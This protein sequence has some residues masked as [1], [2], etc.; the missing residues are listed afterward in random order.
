MDVG[1]LMTCR[2]HHHRPHGELMAIGDRSGE[3][4]AGVDGQRREDGED[5]LLERL[6]QE[7]LVVL[8][9]VGPRREP[10][11]GRGQGGRHQVEEGG[12]HAREQDVEP[13][14]AWFNR[15]TREQFMGEPVKR[16]P[17][18]EV[19]IMV[20]EGSRDDPESMLYAFKLHRG[21]LPVLEE[22]NW[23]IPIVVEEF[24]ADGDIDKAVKHAAEKTYGVKDARYTWTDTVRY[25]GIYHAIPPSSEAL[26][27]LDCHS[28]GGRLDWKGLGY[29]EDP[30]EVLFEKPGVR[31]RV[32]GRTDSTGPA[33]YN[34][35][36]SRRRALSVRNH[37]VEAGLEIALPLFDRN[38]GH[39][40]ETLA[41]IKRAEHNTRKVESELSAQLG[42]AK[43]R[44][45]LAGRQLATHEEK[46]APAASRGLEQA[47]A[48]YRA[49]RL[50]FLE[51]LE[52]QKT[53]ARVRTR[54]LELQRD[55][56][57]AP[58]GEGGGQVHRG[59]RVIDD[60]VDRRAVDCYAGYVEVSPVFP[61]QIDERIIE[62]SSHISHQRRI[63]R[64]IRVGIEMQVK[65][66]ERVRRVVRVFDLLRA[67]EH[68]IFGV[69]ADPDRVIHRLLEV[70]G[71]DA[72]GRYE[73]RCN[74]ECH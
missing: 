21:K 73:Q 6:H 5:A 25:M 69:E 74:S 38:Q 45:S 23:L 72:R 16:V 15:K 2:V 7:L 36:L 56:H 31:V 33:V 70:L 18:G 55:L 14:Y 24:F 59:D 20:P 40:D 3:R 54:T 13:V 46:I 65:L 44:R 17:T 11:A 64:P 9:E 30:L 61:R 8:V 68:M 42:L 51:L 35:D 62:G 32:E 49:G 34:L 58:G 1:Q 67:L 50:S 66:A 53:F 52:A 71:A 10:D 19:G 12:L 60:W 43:R 37:F 28:S 41:G 63:L 26:G 48:G 22:K 4:V 27:C 39:I 57:L 29:Q 47:R